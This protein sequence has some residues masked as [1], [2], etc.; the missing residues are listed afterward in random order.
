MDTSELL[1]KPGIARNRAIIV[2]VWFFLYASFTLLVPPLL[3]DA[4]S[5]HAEV[6]REMLVRHDWITLYANGIR[7]LEKAPLHYWLMAASF[8]L[9][10]PHTAAARLPLALAA[11]ALAFT[12]EA[13]ARRAFQSERAGFYSALILLTSF[14]I[15][16]FSR[17]N[18]PD[19]IV[20]LWITLALLCFW[21]TE[22]QS[23][24]SRLLA[25]AFAAACAL[26]VLTKGLI[27]IIFPVLI[28]LVYLALTRRSLRAVISRIGQLHPISSAIVFFAIATPWHVLIALANPAQGYP[29]HL[30]FAHGHWTVP[31]PTDGNVH[32][33]LW[34]Y[35][36]NEQV[37]RYLNLRVPRDYDTVPLAL[38]WGLVLVWMM[39]W[40][41]F[42]FK[43]L[44][45]V[46]LR[47]ALRPRS[48]IRSLAEAESTRV[49][50][51]V[52]AALPM[53]F[54][55]FSTRQEYYVLPSLPPLILLV[56]GWLSDEASEAETFAV[57]SP[58]TRSGQ[59]IAVVLLA[60]G[61][62]AALIAGF[63]AL[64]GQS[65]GP[66]VD[67]ASLLRQNPGDYALSFGHFLDLDARA[68]GAFQ[69]PLILTAIVCFGGALANW[70]L[71]R[72]YRPHAANLCIAT[73]SIGFLV[74]A[75]IG[76]QTFAPVLSSYRLAEAIAPQLRPDDL[77]VIHGE[78][79][80]GSTLGF[81]LRRNDIHILNGRSSN[82]W[83]G[84][85]FPDAPHIFEDNT[86]IAL[87][88][89]GVRRVFLWQDLSDP[90]PPLP[91]EAYL[92]AQS[93]GKEI[94]SNHPDPY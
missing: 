76:L 5:V 20:C 55:S 41:A 87:E 70:L 89:T 25:W 53:V 58:L 64:R 9:F 88:W 35:F 46:P 19:I 21:L 17:I 39:P 31:L 68:M 38:F 23:K 65:V 51:G 14:G 10:G 3:D 52:W 44:A 15:F 37:L 22:Q 12:L 74:A 69:R 77:I 6:A 91:T 60:L 66:D 82:L 30:A 1:T 29:G 67:L 45:R 83:Y 28:V 8:R 78:Y 94:L 71:R 93:G 90:L 2:A 86:S 33:W 24:P 32:G 18:I 63:F 34:F 79:E 42:L 49:L 7:Y 13:F 11:L 80:A 57:P 85:F 73:A 61:S 62:L 4:D 36:V 48:S 40:S 72:N 47:K 43:A 16:I 81:Y 27:G 92:I 59:R 75:H 56:A 84:S 50:L 54:F 26:D